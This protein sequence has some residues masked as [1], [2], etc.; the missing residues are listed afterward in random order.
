MLTKVFHFQ[1]DIFF[2]LFL[3][4][5]S[6]I[7]CNFGLNVFRYISVPGEEIEFAKKEI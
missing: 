7:H 2:I 3:V 5:K 4:L 1:T 6:E